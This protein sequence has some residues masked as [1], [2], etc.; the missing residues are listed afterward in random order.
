MYYWLAVLVN[1]KPQ[2]KLIRLHAREI[3]AIAANKFHYKTPKQVLTIQLYSVIKAVK[4]AI[5]I[6]LIKIQ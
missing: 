4:M 6:Q 1:T 2:R 3:N 5:R